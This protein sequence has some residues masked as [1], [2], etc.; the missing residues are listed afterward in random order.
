MSDS[1][2]MRASTFEIIAKGFAQHVLPEGLS[3]N[4]VRDAARALTMN[5]RLRKGTN[6]RLTGWAIIRESAT[7]CQADL[8]ATGLTSGDQRTRYE[9]F[10]AE[11]MAFTEPAIFLQ[12]TKSTVNIS[13]VF[14]TYDPRVTRVCSPDCC[15]TF[16]ATTEPDKSAGVAHRNIFKVTKKFNL[17]LLHAL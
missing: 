2:Q 11:L 8:M 16:D 3:N 15:E 14:V 1:L 10:A 6:S 12:F 13:H 5:H 7:T 17:G 9:A 4:P